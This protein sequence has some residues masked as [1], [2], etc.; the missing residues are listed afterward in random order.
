MNKQMFVV[1]IIAVFL[2]ISISFSTA[3]SS[4]TD[5]N[6][7]TPLYRIRTRRAIG[8]KLEKIG[9]YI[10]TKFIGTRLFFIPFQWITNEDELLRHRFQ[11]R[12]TLF[13]FTCPYNTL[14]F[15]L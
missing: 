4:T 13:D 5:E 11:K 3:V 7:E 6:K 8:E 9:D 14:C 12:D 1:S 10:K 2:L 15:L